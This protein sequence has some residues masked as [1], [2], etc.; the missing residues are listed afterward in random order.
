M[1]ETLYKNHAIHTTVTQVLG[2]QSD[3][4]LFKVPSPLN[5]EQRWQLERAFEIAKI[6]QGYLDQTPSTLVSMPY[7]ANLQSGMSAVLSGLSSFRSEKNPTYL[8]TLSQRID[9][10]IPHLSAFAMKGKTPSN[11]KIGEIVDGLRTQSHDAVKALTKEKE[12]LEQKI[13]SLVADI[14]TQEAKVSELALAVE[15]HKKEIVAVKAEV[16]GEYATTET[17]LRAEFATAILKMKGEYEEFSKKTK[18]AA[19]AHLTE[20]NSKEEQAKK[21]LE[22]IGSDAIAGNY[23]NTAVKESEAAD[24]WRIGTIAFFG[25]GVLVALTAFGMHFFHPA[26][27]DNFWAFAMRFVTAIAIATPAFYTARESARHRTNA[28]RARQRDIELASL[29]PFIELLSQE[30]KD[31]IRM[32]LVERYFG[33][34]IEPHEIKQPLNVKEIIE[35]V[36]ATSDG[37]AKVAK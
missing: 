12:T 23:R 17:A 27:L 35:L 36:K 13:A 3:D 25:I 7:L 33:S 37:I 24:R 22:L 15:A 34:D 26:T 16:Q 32:K 4:E 11:G 18:T 20:L 6:V 9:E 1:S 19:E 29:N 2:M 10:L 5:D 21:I 14:T 31:E 28:D 30:Q 8:A